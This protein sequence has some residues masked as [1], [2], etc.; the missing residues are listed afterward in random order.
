M[1]SKEMF[2]KSIKLLMNDR[3]RIISE[4]DGIMFEVLD[5]FDDCKHNVTIKKKKNGTVLTC[6][7]FHCS[8]YPDSICYNKL[9]CLDYYKAKI[10]KLR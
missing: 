1:V 9:A 2:Q 10:L 7:C 5:E 8:N 4:R 6:D 3:I